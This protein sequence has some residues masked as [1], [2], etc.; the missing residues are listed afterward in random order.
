MS[1]IHP[2]VKVPAV[3]GTIVAIVLAVLAALTTVPAAAPYVAI[4]TTVITA[5]TGYLTYS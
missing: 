2:K 5:V 3:V 1:T 4:G